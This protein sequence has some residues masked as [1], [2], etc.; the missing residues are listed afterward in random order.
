[1]VAPLDTTS[2]AD[3][4]NVSPSSFSTTFLPKPPE[5]STIPTS[6]DKPLQ[7]LPRTEDN[8]CA[9]GGPPSSTTS[10]T[11]FNKSAS[12]LD[13]V[14]D[15]VIELVTVKEEEIT[16]DH[17][18]EEEVTGVSTVDS[19]G[20]GTKTLSSS[21]SSS[22]VHFPKP[23]EGLHET[24][25]P[26]FLKK[27]FEMVEDP[28]TNSIVSWNENGNSFV[29]WDAYEFSKQL[30]PKYF[31]HSNFSSFIRQLN[32]YGFKKMDPDRWEFANEGFRR[33]KRHLLKNI[34]RR[35]RYN[36]QQQGA[37]N[38]YGCD[39]ANP[40][41]EAEIKNL[42]DDQDLLRVE[43]SNLRLQQEESEN[44]IS[45]V[46]ERIRFAHSKQLQVVLFLIKAAEN[47]SFIHNLLG[48]IKQKK[49]VNEGE[50]CKKRKLLQVPETS[51][52]SHSQSV[53]SR[54]QAQEQL[55]TM[56]TQL[57]ELLGDE[58]EQNKTSP[59]LFETPLSNEFCSPIQDQKTNM[60]CNTNDEESVYHLM[61]EELLDGVVLQNGV[62][63]ELDVNDSKFYL[64]LEDLLGKPRTWGGYA[65]E[66]AGC[67]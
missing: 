29:V 36:K 52:A 60:M 61:S 41:L 7:F 65:T 35:S 31:K 55:A 2:S 14:E 23:I 28:E 26:P 10:S 30:L 33:G 11:E 21:S 43:I 20:F 12:A 6:P 25:P 13:E 63:E 46:E 53:N 8:P 45:S 38:V 66:L 34:K 50:F 27:T 22:S 58:T 67:I 64:E 15:E 49:E 24:C 18:V 57:T 47:R 51:P 5:E 19:Y 32:T 40:N 56:Q 9:D 59:K 37:G 44:Q 48:R 62:D 17:E 16:D 4:G 39:S 1:M 54:N 3:G 42:K